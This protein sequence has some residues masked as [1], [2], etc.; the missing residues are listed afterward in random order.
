MPKAKCIY[1]DFERQPLVRAFFLLKENYFCTGILVIFADNN[2]QQLFAI[3]L[4]HQATRSINSAETM[5]TRSMTAIDDARRSTVA[6]ATAHSPL[7]CLPRETRDH[8]YDLV[9]L[10]EEKLLYKFT[11]KAGERPQ[12]AYSVPRG[13]S[14]ACSEF[15]AE[16]RDAVE[17]RVISLM[18][19][20]DHNGLRLSHFE[21]LS[22]S[23]VKV[24]MSE[25][26]IED[27]PAQNIHAVRLVVPALLITS[28]ARTFGFDG[29][30][31]RPQAVVVF[32]FKFPESERLGPLQDIPLSWDKHDS[33]DG[34]FA[35]PERYNP[36]VQQVRS[37]SKK[38]DWKG[39]MRE[40]MVWHVFFAR[41]TR[42]RRPQKSLVP[43]WRA[44][45]IAS[46]SREQTLFV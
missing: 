40:N 41:Y 20:G 46:L 11:L 36:L 15:M 38:V 42:I 4:Q 10:S 39:C 37:I 24:K 9:A 16:Y 32:Q 18:G 43:V 28:E 31:E 6:E 21:P 1:S 30:L 13:A 34:G 12:K 22:E 45:H 27:K 17:R 8:I 44:R 26:K 29:P 14:Y 35:T 23:V 3:T 2:T 5:K 19:K 7:F 25:G 33:R